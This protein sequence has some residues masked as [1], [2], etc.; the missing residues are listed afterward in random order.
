MAGALKEEDYLE[1]IRQAGFVQLEKEEAKV[2]HYKEEAAKNLGASIASIAV[3]AF[4][5]E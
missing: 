3:K 2:D 1:K 5:P 4:K